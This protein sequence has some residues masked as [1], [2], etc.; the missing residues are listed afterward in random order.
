MAERQIERQRP[1]RQADGDRDREPAARLGSCGRACRHG[2][3]PRSNVAG[4]KDATLDLEPCRCRLIGGQDTAR[5][6]AV[7]LGQLVAI[8]GEIVVR[9]RPL[10]GSPLPE[11]PNEKRYGKSAKTRTGPPE[12]PSSLMGATTSCAPLSGSLSRFARFSS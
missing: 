8:D 9:R 2:R 11:R 12:P 3:T 5:H 6:V 10:A 4:G 7:D 1:E